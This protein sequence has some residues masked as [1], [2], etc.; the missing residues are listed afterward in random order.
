M[1]M[2]S[3]Y[4]LAAG[5]AVAMLLLGS[6]Y[7]ARDYWVG[8]FVQSV[9]TDQARVALDQET[10]LSSL[11]LDSS[12]GHISID[13]LAFSTL[14]DPKQQQNFAAEHVELEA[15]ISGVFSPHV[16]VR[17]ARVHNAEVLLEYIAPGV[18]NLKMVEQSYQAFV[19]QCKAQGKS[20]RL[21]WDLERVEFYTVRFRLV[22]YDGQQLA[23]VI[24]PRISLDSLSSSLTATSNLALILQQVQLSVIQETLK[25]RVEGDYDFA[26]MLR[27][28]RRELP[29]STLLSKE[30]VDRIKGAGR[31]LLKKWIEK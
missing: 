4:L 11:V 13:Q 1:K 22:D 23:D 2:T 25:G 18:S 31:S 20:R 30:R 10:L 27:L 29:N 5:V 19:Q 17:R 26:G 21:E 7:Y 12:T 24:I 3:K 9:L 14:D 6:A 28:V 15:Q 16:R 8:Q